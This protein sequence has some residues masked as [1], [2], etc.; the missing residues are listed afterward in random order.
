MNWFKLALLPTSRVMSNFFEGNLLT[1]KRP[2]PSFTTSLRGCFLNILK[3][4]E[5]ESLYVK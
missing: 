2:R 1:I 3:C 4:D 5:R